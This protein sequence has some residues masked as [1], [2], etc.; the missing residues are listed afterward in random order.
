MTIGSTNNAGLAARAVVLQGG[1]DFD[2]CVRYARWR[3]FFN[4]LE[5]MKQNY[6]RPRPGS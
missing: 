1:R 6:G 2:A 4:P 3:E 5:A